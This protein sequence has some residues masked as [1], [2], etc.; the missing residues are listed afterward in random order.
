[1]IR[2]AS[3]SDEPTVTAARSPPIRTIASLP[4]KFLKWR[5]QNFDCLPRYRVS[6]LTPG[7]WNV[8]E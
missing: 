6:T 4:E 7:S 1:V 8:E 5:S 2:P 3:I